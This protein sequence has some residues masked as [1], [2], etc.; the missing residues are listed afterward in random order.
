MIQCDRVVRNIGH[1]LQKDQL[2]FIKHRP[3]ATVSMI[4]QWDL[5]STQWDPHC[6]PFLSSTWSVVFVDVHTPTSMVG[7]YSPKKSLSGVPDPREV[8]NG[9]ERFKTQSTP[10]VCKGQ[11]SSEC[12]LSA[13][14]PC[15]SRISLWSTRSTL[16]LC[17]LLW[18]QD[19]LSEH[20][21]TIRRRRGHKKRR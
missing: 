8:G 5:L 16:F 3:T 13:C 11:E 15:E 18:K 17:L 1:E 7:W 2:Y 12:F 20:V 19:I 6:L 4:H 14:E 21:H 9:G 10:V